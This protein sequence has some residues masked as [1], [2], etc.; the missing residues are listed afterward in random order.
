MGSSQGMGTPGQAWSLGRLW[1][2]EE[3]GGRSRNPGQEQHLDASALLPL[4]TPTGIWSPA[5][6]NPAQGISSLHFPGY[7]RCSQRQSWPW[8]LSCLLSRLS[9]PSH[10]LGLA[11]WAVVSGTGINPTNSAAEPFKDP[12]VD[13]LL[14]QIH[15][16]P[17]TLMSQTPFC[18][19]KS[20]S[21]HLCVA[22]S[23]GALHQLISAL[24][25]VSAAFLQS[26]D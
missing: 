15:Y 6:P 18:C 10:P 21:L 24:S 22:R 4:H 11:A 25:S 23:V 7:S 12:D 5:N 8:G 26:Q 9:V 2:N 13:A 16:F 14:V 1:S 19:H 17:Q 20:R 3:L